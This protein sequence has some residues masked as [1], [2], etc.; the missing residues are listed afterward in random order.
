MNALVI[1]NGIPV[2]VQR[3]QFLHMDEGLSIE[4]G[5]NNQYK[6]K[7]KIYL[8]N[9]RLI[10][11]K[12]DPGRQFSSFTVPYIFIQK[13]KYNKKLLGGPV[14]SGTMTTII[15]GGLDKSNNGLS[16]FCITFNDSNT[17]K[18]FYNLLEREINKSSNPNENKSKYQ[19][20]TSTPTLPIEQIFPDQFAA[21]KQQQILKQ[22]GSHKNVIYSNKQQVVVGQSPNDAPMSLTHDYRAQKA[23]LFASNSLKNVSASGPIAGASP[24][25]A[26]TFKRHKIGQT[27]IMDESKKSHN[28]HHNAAQRNR[29]QQQKQRKQLP[30]YNAYID[31]DNPDDIVLSVPMN[32]NEFADEIEGKM[33]ANVNGNGYMYGIGQKYDD[34][35]GQKGKDIA[36]A[37][38]LNDDDDDDDDYVQQVNM[39]TATIVINPPLKSSKSPKLKRKKSSKNDHDA[40]PE[41]PSL[42]DANSQGLYV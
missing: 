37:V 23:K 14:V 7:G 1:R 9:F 11:L 31:P 41:T 28:N 17:G 4:I 25:N 15:N 22:Q 13:H 26:Q 3:E 6:G 12:R 35:H 10:F 16:K 24:V 40:L 5:N 19:K 42:N 27:V 8:T 34:K 2:P 18:A 21:Y 29:H 38:N 36:V 32:D 30:Q 20:V 39:K 33:D